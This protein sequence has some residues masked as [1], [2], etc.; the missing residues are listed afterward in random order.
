MFQDV[1]EV[2]VRRRQSFVTPR[3]ACF[4]QGT[5]ETCFIFPIRMARP[6]AAYRYFRNLLYFSYTPG[7][8]R[9]CGEGSQKLQFRWCVVGSGQW[10][11]NAE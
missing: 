9:K 5:S 8:R 4:G 1:P 10:F 11:L 2:H 6:M 7:V 3:S